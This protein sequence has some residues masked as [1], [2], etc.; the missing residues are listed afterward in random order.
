[1]KVKHILIFP[2]ACILI[3]SHPYLSVGQDLPASKDSIYALR[4]SLTTLQ[5]I[6]LQ[7]HAEVASFKLELDTA[8]RE[9]KR[10]SRNLEQLKQ[11]ENELVP[12]NEALNRKIAE[13]G[14]ELH[15][16]NT[17]LEEQLRI[18]RY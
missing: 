6:L 18:E 3:F 4:D 10:L 11:R 9:I 16:K 7:K 5:Y 14:A 12:L 13:L 1:M 2:I 17:Y 15:A 8:Q